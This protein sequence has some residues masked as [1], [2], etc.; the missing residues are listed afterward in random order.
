MLKDDIVL[1]IL[2]TPREKELRALGEI[3]RDRTHWEYV[4]I[5]R[6]KEQD[7]VWNLLR[8]IKAS[9]PVPSGGIPNGSIRVPGVVPDDLQVWPVPYGTPSY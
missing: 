5:Q 4:G 9:L 6:R 1:T 3:A 7:F 2:E 8:E